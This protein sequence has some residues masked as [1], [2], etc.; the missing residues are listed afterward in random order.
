MRPLHCAIATYPWRSWT[1]CSTRLATLFAPRYSEYIQ[2]S[3]WCMRTISTSFRRCVSRACERSPGRLR[4]HPGKQG[5]SPLFMAPTQRIILRCFSRQ[6]A[7][8]FDYGQHRGF[9]I[10]RHV[11]GIATDIDARSILEPGP[12][13][14]TL[15]EYSML[16]VDFLRLVTREG[17]RLSSVR[18]PSLCISVSSS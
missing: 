8:A 1:R 15:F 17:A 9:D 11:A 14:C 5:L 6:T 12:Q 2:R 18:N 16:D 13:R 4:K 7:M 10:F 3:L